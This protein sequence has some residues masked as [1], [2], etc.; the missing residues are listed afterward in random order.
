M[1][2]VSQH[3]LLTVQSW[4]CKSLESS[5]HQ[6]QVGSGVGGGGFS[7]TQPAVGVGQGWVTLAPPPSELGVFGY[8]TRIPWDEVF[9]PVPALAVVTA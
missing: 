4:S 9:A 3:V 8:P 1:A 7:Q 6:C 5:W 2:P